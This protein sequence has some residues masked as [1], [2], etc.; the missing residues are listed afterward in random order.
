MKARV[1]GS[2]LL[3]AVLIITG[4]S[5]K[6]GGGGIATI[7]GMAAPE[8]LAKW[9]E[10]E[11]DTCRLLLD[12]HV[13]VEEEEFMTISIVGSMDVASKGMYLLTEA[14]VNK[15]GVPEKAESAIYMV[16]DWL[17]SGTD[18]GY[19]MDWCKESVSEDDWGKYDVTK[20]KLSLLNNYTEVTFLGTEVMQGID[21]YKIDVKPDL[22]TL[23]GWMTKESNLNNIDDY[24]VSMTVW[25]AKEAFYLVEEDVYMTLTIEGQTGDISMI[26][27]M[28][29]FD[30]PV[31]I[32]LPAEAADA[33]EGCYSYENSSY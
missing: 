22:T 27:T 29:S 28:Y 5:C 9:Y 31:F 26:I 33:Y 11:Y 13:T 32:S 20:D 15:S 21:C 12:E 7:D 23:L 3:C 25:V 2:M 19:G 14:T 8:V 6:G 18:T 30:S 1:L 24:D 17:Y 10:A 16:G 4:V